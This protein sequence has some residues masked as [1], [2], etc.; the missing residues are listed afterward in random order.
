MVALFAAVS[1]QAVGLCPSWPELEDGPSGDYWL[2]GIIGQRPVRM[3]LERGGGVVVGAFYYTDDWAPFVL[4]GRW[5]NGDV[6][7]VTHT[8]SAAWS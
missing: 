2:E 5:K 6:V 4:R 8:T 3:H 1:I 7:E